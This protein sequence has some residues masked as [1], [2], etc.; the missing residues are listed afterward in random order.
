MNIHALGVKSGMNC[1]AFKIE[2]DNLNHVFIWGYLCAKII[3]NVF[4]EHSYE[5]ILFVLKF[6]ELCSLGFLSSGM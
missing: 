5:K 4:R 3:G 6:S 1:T 2:L